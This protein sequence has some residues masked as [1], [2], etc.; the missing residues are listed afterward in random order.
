MLTEE[1]PVVNCIN[2]LQA[3]FAQIFLRQKK[4][5]SQTVIR[6]KLRKA[7]WYEKGAHKVL[8]KLTTLGWPTIF[9]RGPHLVLT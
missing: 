3:A 5:Q 9:V 2:I 1:F 7:L 4:F 6:E 8:L